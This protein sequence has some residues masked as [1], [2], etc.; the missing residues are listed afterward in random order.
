MVDS[1]RLQGKGNKQGSKGFLDY[2]IGGQFSAEEEI[3]HD[4]IRLVYKKR[5]EAGIAREQARKDLPLSNYTEA[6]WKIDLKNLMGFLGLRMDSHAQ[7]EIRDYATI[8]GEEI[9]AKWVP[10]TWQAFN[11]YHTLRNAMILTALETKIVYALSLCNGWA[12]TMAV[13]RDYGWLKKS[14]KTGRLKKNRE[15]QECEEKLKMLGLEIPW[16]KNE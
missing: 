10:V 3:L 1:W 11:D 14:N 16:Q 5:L 8:I 13:A 9:V 4:Q 2:N 12:E 15:R 6:Y 7:K